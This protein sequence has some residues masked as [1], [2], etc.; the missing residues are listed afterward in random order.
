MTASA[1]GFLLICGTLLV[2]ALFVV[3][4]KNLVH[5][6]L[7]LAVTLVATAGL[8]LHLEADFLAGTQVLLYAGGVVTLMIFAVLLTRKLSGKAVFQSSQERLRGAIAACGV[9]GLFA[10]GILSDKASSLL[11]PNARPTTPDDLARGFLVDHV[12]A[13]EVLSVLLVAAM[14]GA[15]AIARREDA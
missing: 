3:L 10:F 4:T 13:F 2:S 6:V 8:Y 12:L 14:I 7:W 5:S 9:A 1:L 15:I 11:N